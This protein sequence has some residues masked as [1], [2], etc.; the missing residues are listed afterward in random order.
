MGVIGQKPDVSQHVLLG[1]CGMGLFDVALDFEQRIPHD[2]PKA[3]AEKTSDWFR[4]VYIY[5]S[6]MIL[7]D[8]STLSV[9][10]DL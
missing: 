2:C 5:I 8:Q 3:S 7:C 4:R 10:A 1:L 9:L 6:D